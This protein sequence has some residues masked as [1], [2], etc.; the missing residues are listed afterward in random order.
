[1]LKLQQYANS[2]VKTPVK[3]QKQTY[4]ILNVWDDKK[5]TMLQILKLE[6]PKDPRWLSITEATN[7]NFPGA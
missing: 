2:P 1:M 7:N 5:K 3:T 4:H 6:G